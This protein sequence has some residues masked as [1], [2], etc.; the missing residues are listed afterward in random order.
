[1]SGMGI[2]VSRRGGDVRIHAG[3]VL[4]VGHQNDFIS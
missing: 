4:K 2:S 1:M 3:G